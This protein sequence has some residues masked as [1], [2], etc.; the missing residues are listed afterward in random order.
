MEKHLDSILKNY[1]VSDF[2][3]N[4]I[5]NALNKDYNLN[6]LKTNLNIKFIIDISR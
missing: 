4:K 1:S 5:K 3:I 6:N 2:E